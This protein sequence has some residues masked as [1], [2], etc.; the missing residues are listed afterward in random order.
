MA[1]N[2]FVDTA[3]DDDS[4][5]AVANVSS[6]NKGHGA[7][8]AATAGCFCS[9]FT[10]TC[11]TDWTECNDTHAPVINSWLR[12]LYK[13]NLPNT[14]CDTAG[15][16]VQQQRTTSLSLSETHRDTLL[17][18]GFLE[19][20]CYYFR[21]PLHAPQA[22]TF[23]YIWTQ[24]WKLS[25]VHSYE[26]CSLFIGMNEAKMML[27]RNTQIFH[28]VGPI[29]SAH[30]RLQLAKTA[31][32]WFSIQ[33]PWTLIM[34]VKQFILWGLWCSPKCIHYIADASF[35]MLLMGQ[36]LLGAPPASAG[37]AASSASLVQRVEGC[38]WGKMA[39]G[40]RNTTWG[41]C[42]KK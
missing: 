34:T 33:L 26:S 10:K 31:S 35:A 12:L 7:V 16:K 41:S 37:A 5:P 36:S 14:D 2:T 25:P 8:Q 32:F 17:A 15:Q 3:D 39:A 11:D 20:H 29:E 21:E 1:K 28:V 42:Y 40:N 22:R 13:S 9:S 30:E 23:N 19:I 18:L 38:I 4:R 6:A 27:D 24:P